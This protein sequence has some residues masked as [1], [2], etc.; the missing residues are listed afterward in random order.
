[1]GFSPEIS[2]TNLNRDSRLRGNRSN[3]AKQYFFLLTPLFRVG[4]GSFKEKWA[5]VLKI[6]E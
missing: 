6:L 3:T 2:C 1:M 4:V 5:L